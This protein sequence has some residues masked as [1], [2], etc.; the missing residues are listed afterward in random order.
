MAAGEHVI[1][2]D[3]RDLSGARAAAGLYFARLDAPGGVRVRKLA[4]AR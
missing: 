4:L 3:G 1:D 2:W